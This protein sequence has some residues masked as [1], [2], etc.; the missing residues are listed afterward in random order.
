[1]KMNGLSVVRMRTLA[2]GAVAGL[3]LMASCSED[4]VEFSAIDSENVQDE[5]ITE[6]FYED[7][8]DMAN[9]ALF[10]DPETAGG[11][12]SSG[13]R[14]IVVNDL[15]FQCATA[16]I[17]TDPNSTLDVPKG[18]ITITFDGNC[19]DPR[20]NK[21]SG[22]LVIVYNGK[23]FLPGSSRTFTLVNYFINDIKVEGTRTVT[24]VSGSTD[25]APKFNIVLTGGKVTWPNGDLA[26]REANR[27]REW[28]RAANPLNDEWRISGSASGTNRKG[29]SYQME[30]PAVDPLVYKRECAVS[31]RIFMAVAGTKNL[32]TENKL[33]SI[34]YGDGECDRKV[35]ITVNGRS[36]EVTV[37]NNF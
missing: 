21:R 5:A 33:I 34:D 1:M 12:V 24:N 4:A 35:V 28:I 31:D 11:R 29:R 6:S 10:S 18:T 22:Q 19:L 30:I 20:G 8:D 14:T 7:A 37:N 25:E 9:V 2:Y 17:E 27:T 16:V 15:R 32:T 26:T 23:R 13:A 36:R 3:L